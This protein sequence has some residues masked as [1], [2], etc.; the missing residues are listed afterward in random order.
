MFQSFGR[1]SNRC[2]RYTHCRWWQRKP[3]EIGRGFESLVPQENRYFPAEPAKPQV[4]L[5]PLKRLADQG[6]VAPFFFPSFPKN[7]FQAGFSVAGQNPDE[8]SSA[9]SKKV[10]VRLFVAEIMAKM[11]G[12]GLD[13]RIFAVIFVENCS[14]IHDGFA[15]RRTIGIR[16][17]FT[18]RK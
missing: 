16:S 13:R 3:G 15:I 12:M 10:M 9:R 7:N 8:K 18:V 11:C 6:T 2:R 17:Y 14:E 1:Y 5:S 4:L